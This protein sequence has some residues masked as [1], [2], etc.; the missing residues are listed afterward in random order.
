ML[1]A[2]LVKTI[3]YNSDDSEFKAWGEFTAGL[4]VFILFYLF[5]FLTTSIDITLAAWNFSGICQDDW[6]II[7]KGFGWL[8]HCLDNISSWMDRSRDSNSPLLPLDPSPLSV[9][10]LPV[11][12]WSPGFSSLLLPSF[13]VCQPSSWCWQKSG[14][15][16]LRNLLFS[17]FL[18]LGLWGANSCVLCTVLLHISW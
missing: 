10:L 5:S 3:V 15:P 6:F 2:L 1:S 11:F 9:P 14:F 17:V 8:S 13:L 16:S 12:L 4:F 7:A 18:Y